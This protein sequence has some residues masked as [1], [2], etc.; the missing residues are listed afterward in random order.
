MVGGGD[1][2]INEA[3]C[4]MA[5]SAVPLAILPG[6]TANV[7][8]REIGLPLDIPSAAKQLLSCTPRRLSLGLA[9][10][11]YF[12]LMAGVGFDARVIQA[13]S[14]HH[15]KTFGMATYIFEALR[16]GLFHA[17]LP[18]MLKSAAHSCLSTFAC[19]AKA[20]HYGPIRMA[21]EADL[22]SNQFFVYCFH[23][24][25]RLRYVLY[26][27]ALLS[28]KLDRLSDVSRF[29]ATEIT[30]APASS[31]DPVY[32]QVDGELLGLLPYKITIVPDALTL[33]VPSSHSA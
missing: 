2:P 33:L 22:F 17:P 26:A 18:F 12:L 5:R 24:R 19:I 1:G 32:L 7:L 23:S 11:R 15:K 28:G 21:R 30:C 13:V 10:S 3:V 27:L 14:A 4:G 16:Q 6:G 29:A 8:A 20:Q 31:A 9:G 25:S